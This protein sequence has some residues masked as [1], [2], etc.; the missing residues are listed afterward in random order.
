M[1]LIWFSLVR[2]VLRSDYPNAP[3]EQNSH[4]NPKGGGFGDQLSWLEADLRKTQKPWKIVIGH[5]PFFSGKF[6]FYWSFGTFCFQGWSGTGHWVFEIIRRTHLVQYSRDIMLMFSLLRI[7][8]HTKGNFN[9]RIFV[10]GIQSLY[11]LHSKEF[12]RNL[13]LRNP[14]HFDKYILSFIR[15]SK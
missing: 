5:R 8:M 10:F 15:V 4:L 6:L 13:Y 3:S 7:Y 12:D 9:S 14:C 2:C 1:S 11:L